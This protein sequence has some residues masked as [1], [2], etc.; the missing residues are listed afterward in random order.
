MLLLNADAVGRHGPRANSPRASRGPS[1]SPSW[2][3]VA[4]SWCQGEGR[5]WTG[6]TC[7]IGMWSSPASCYRSSVILLLTD[8]PKTCASLHV[9]PS[10]FPFVY[11][12]LYVEQ[13]SN[14]IPI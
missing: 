4:Y 11:H 2:T 13:F 6:R 7:T 8:T 9:S 3:A 1:T 5:K 12:Y 10:E 14:P